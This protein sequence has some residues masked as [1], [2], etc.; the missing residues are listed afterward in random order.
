MEVLE[1]ENKKLENT[2]ESLNEE[3][4]RLKEQIG[5]AINQSKT[6]EDQVQAVS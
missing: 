4:T 3:I 1:R 5:I 6:L 2:I